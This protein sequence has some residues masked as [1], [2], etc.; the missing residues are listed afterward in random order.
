MLLISVNS[1]YPRREVFSPGAISVFATH[2]CKIASPEQ[3]RVF[4]DLILDNWDELAE[5]SQAV[6]A[7][8]HLVQHVQSDE[9][10]SP[11]ACRIC[12]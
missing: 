9:T 12:H 8:G 11:C 2:F 1:L 5:E 10:V 4:F 6:R 7:V 3:A